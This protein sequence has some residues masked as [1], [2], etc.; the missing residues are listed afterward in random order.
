MPVQAYDP[1]FSHEGNYFSLMRHKDHV[2][3]YT[4]S[5]IFS[6]TDNLPVDKVNVVVQK[7]GLNLEAEVIPSKHDLP[8]KK[9]LLST[10][11]S[12]GLDSSFPFAMEHEN[13]A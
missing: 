1:N 10:L 8:L 12:E 6:H 11:L 3:K 13:F 9:K 7:L 2:N 5:N 4:I